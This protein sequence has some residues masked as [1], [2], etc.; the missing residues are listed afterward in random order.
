[1]VAAAALPANQGYK[2]GSSDNYHQTRA[3]QLLEQALRES[4]QHA[5]A[6]QYKQEIEASQQK[7][8]LAQ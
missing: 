6:V 8:Q 2:S 1:V 4:P 5:N 3:L 7:Q